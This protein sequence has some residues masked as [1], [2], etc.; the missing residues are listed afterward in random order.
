LFLS[1]SYEVA[2]RRVGCVIAGTP[3]TVKTE[4]LR[5]I[6]TAGVNY[7]L[8]QL[9]FGN[10]GHAQTLRTLDLFAREVLPAIRKL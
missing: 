1:G 4:L 10:L 8:I 9:A 5:D 2:R 6:A 7:P 3:E